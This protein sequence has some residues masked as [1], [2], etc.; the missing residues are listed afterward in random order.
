MADKLDAPLGSLSIS[1]SVRLGEN[2]AAVLSETQSVCD[3]KTVLTKNHVA[4][5]DEL[6]PDCFLDHLEPCLGKSIINEIKDKSGKR[7]RSRHILDTLKRFPQEIFEEFCRVIAGLYPSL[8]ELLTNRKPS[9]EEM[10]YYITNFRR[11][12]CKSIR[13][14]GNKPDSLRDRKINFDTQ[15]VEL[16]LGED[17]EFG[18]K[19]SADFTPR[20]DHLPKPC[21]SPIDEGCL[22]NIVIEDI[23]PQQSSGERI[24]IKGRAGIG[25]STLSQNVVQ[26]WAKGDLATSF[27]TAFL[28]NLRKLVHIT[29]EMTLSEV[30]GVYAEYVTPSPTPDQPA[31]QW[32]KNNSEKIL[33]FTDGVDELPELHKLFCRTPKLTSLNMKATPLDWCVNIMQKN[34]LEQSCVVVVSRPFTGLESMNYDRVFDVL[35]FT[36]NKV[37]DFVGCNVEVSRQALVKHTLQSNTVLLSVSSIPFYCRAICRVLEQDASS[38]D[39]SLTTYTRITAYIIQQLALRSSSEEADLLT[40][41]ILDCFPELAKLAHHG[42]LGGANGDPKIVFDESDLNQAGLTTEKLQKAKGSGLLVVTSIKGNHRT[43]THLQF[44]FVHLYIQD[45]LASVHMMNSG[46]IEEL[47]RY[48][49]TGY[50]PDRFNLC[51]LFLIG[52]SLDEDN[53]HIRAIKDATRTVQPSGGSEG[54]I[55]DSTMNMIHELFV[56]VKETN[57][58]DLFLI[59]LQ[60]VYEGQNEDLAKELVQL[61][62]LHRTFSMMNML[63][64]VV[65]L[66]AV[67]FVMK[68]AAISQLS[69]FRTRLD[70]ASANEIKGMLK[71]CKI[72]S[73][74]LYENSLSDEAIEYISNGIESSLDIKS[75]NFRQTDITNEGMKHISRGIQLSK[76]LNS[77]VFSVSTVILPIGSQIKNEGMA[78]FSKAITSSSS[79]SSLQLTNCDITDDD[80]V[81]LGEA[82][83]SSTGLSHL[84][85][86]HM[87]ISDEA[88][89]NLSKGI[90][91]SKSLK[92]LKLQSIDLSEEHLIN[93]SDAVKCSTSLEHLEISDCR[94]TDKGMQLLSDGVRFAEKLQY[95]ELF[96]TGVQTQGLRHLSEA[97]KSSTSLSHLNL[98]YEQLTDDAMKYLGTTIGTSSSLKHLGLERCRLTMEGVVHLSGG[99]KRSHSLNHLTIAGNV[100]TEEGMR[101]LSEAVKHSTSLCGLELAYNSLTD[102][103]MKYL[104]LAVRSSACLSQLILRSNPITVEGIKYL[105]QGIRTSSCLKHLRLWE[106]ITTESLKILCEAVPLSTSIVHLALYENDITDEGMGYLSECLKRSVTLEH[107]EVAQRKSHTM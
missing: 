80:V 5:V 84:T 41:D 18:K 22:S 46:N 58:R 45:F 68:H 70:C 17:K 60:S 36:T 40:D 20:K 94:L 39:T 88:M 82:L 49:K 8:F 86:N 48:T 77:L 79:L 76:T 59:S 42:L 44:E 56:K 50:I 64:T 75:L 101:H 11:E 98:K 33:I 10:D 69:L 19:D 30:L 4:L 43:D 102:V 61:L 32:L 97:V 104:G 105:C 99:I 51:L 6:D 31:Q 23:L 74:V 1:M 9:R 52:L 90:K 96:Y 81:L 13:G 47:T 15:Y 29:R 85:L 89:R 95:L 26:K 87:K 72:S 100:V 35:G 25:K 16:G 65:D 106:N 78:C 7:E 63:V 92:Q 71:T 67:E 14:S 34:I 24:L 54:N 91:H 2:G 28:L 93:L 27:T 38:E 62:D 83:K 37:M 66:K 55:K 21:E 53:K 73:L 3:H 57:R 103:G 107:L 12:L